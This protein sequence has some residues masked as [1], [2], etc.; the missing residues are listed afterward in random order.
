M[1]LAG[2]RKKIQ[3]S[4][5]MPSTSKE[6]IMIQ[7]SSYMSRKAFDV[8]QKAILKDLDVTLKPPGHPD[9]YDP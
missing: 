9:G 1:C 2:G 6:S 7:G 4:K 3:V 5:I 8:S